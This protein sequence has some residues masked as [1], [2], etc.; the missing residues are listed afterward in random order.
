[1]FTILRKAVL[2]KAAKVQRTAWQSWRDSIAESKAKAELANQF[3]R[4]NALKTALQRQ[5][6]K[7]PS[8]LRHSLENET[9]LALACLLIMIQDTL[10]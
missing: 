10:Q 6:Q 1:M 2:R 4:R 3:C 9:C 5:V 7:G 8:T